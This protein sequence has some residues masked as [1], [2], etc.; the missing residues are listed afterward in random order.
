MDLQRLLELTTPKSGDAA[1]TSTTD[2]PSSGASAPIGRL[3][4]FVL[5]HAVTITSAIT[6]PNFARLITS[7]PPPLSP[8]YVSSSHSEDTS[9]RPEA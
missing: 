1:P 2:L 5:T 3:A 8:S 9:I 6:A 4:G 7:P